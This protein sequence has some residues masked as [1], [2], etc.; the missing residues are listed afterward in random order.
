MLG[1]PKSVQIPETEVSCGVTTPPNLPTVAARLHGLQWTCDKP[2][3]VDSLI[4]KPPPFHLKNLFIWSYAVVYSSRVYIALPNNAPSVQE[5]L[6]ELLCTE[7]AGEASPQRL[8]RTFKVTQ[9]E[10]PEWFSLLEEA[11][12]GIFPNI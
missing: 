10:I 7:E 12:A 1:L 2:G 6:Y 8:A 3:H 11:E 9:L 5:E 4:N